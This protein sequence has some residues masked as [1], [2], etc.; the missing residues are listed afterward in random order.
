MDSSSEA[1][2]VV[3]AVVSP[4]LLGGL[5]DANLSDWLP[6]SQWELGVE[7]FDTPPVLT[8]RTPEESDEL[9]HNSMNPSSL[10]M[11]VCKRSWQYRAR[12][13]NSVYLFHRLLWNK[14]ESLEYHRKHVAKLL[15]P[16]SFAI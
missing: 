3:Q 16:I 5:L 7:G 9:L 11:A 13:V 8:Q 6:Q 14:C 2:R 4:T 1:D 12:L 10:M 15:S